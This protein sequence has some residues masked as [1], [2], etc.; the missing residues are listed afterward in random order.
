MLCIDFGALAMAGFGRELQ[1][2]SF[3]LRSALSRNGITT[4]RALVGLIEHGGGM[5]VIFDDL[6][7]GDAPTAELHDEFV[8]LVEASQI[9]APGELRAVA[10]KSDTEIAVTREVKHKETVDK[11]ADTLVTTEAASTD[12][13]PAQWPSRLKRHVAETAFPAKEAED[14][15]EAVDQRRVDQRRVDK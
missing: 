14:Q 7:E 12:H 5:D 3:Y 1:R 10:N 13:R 4:A 6:F 9:L 15:K 8:R 11:A 2:T